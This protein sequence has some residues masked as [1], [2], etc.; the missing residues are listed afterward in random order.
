[1]HLTAW[2]Y[3]KS[4]KRTVGSFATAIFENLID[5]LWALPFHCGFAPR[6]LINGQV[7]WK[8]FSSQRSF[9]LA[10]QEHSIQALSERVEV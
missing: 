1:M 7:E 10:K 5:G 9:H 2:F 8:K 6:E 4:R 3:K